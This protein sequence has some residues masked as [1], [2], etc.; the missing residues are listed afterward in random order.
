[1]RTL[2]TAALPYAN[3]PLHLG[4]IRSTYLPG[5][6]CARHNRLVGNDALYIC[7]T[8]EH[9]TP[10]EI[11]AAKEKKTPAEFVKYYYE[12]DKKEFSA[13][14]FSFDIFHH[15]ESK[16]NIAITQDIFNKN[17]KN[18]FI[19]KKQV[20]QFYCEK[21]KTYLPD[22]YVRGICPFCS[23]EDQ[24]GDQCEK[25]GRTFGAQDLKSPHCAICGQAPTLK[26][27]EHYFFKLS[28]FKDEL[29]NYIEGNPRFQKEVK[30]YVLNW[31]NELIDWDI[32]RNLKWGVPIPGEKD[33]VFYVWFDAPIGYISSTVALTKDW[34]KYWK[35]KDARLIHFIGK[36]IIYHHYLF[37]PAMLSGSKDGYAAPYAIPTRGHLTLEGKKFSKSRGWYITLEEYLAVFPPDYLRYYMTAI[38]PYSLVDADFSLQEFK[39]KINNELIANYGNFVFRVE[40]LLKKSCDSKVP[41]VEPDAGMLKKLEGAKI[42]IQKD[43]EAFDYKVA[44]DKTMA[45]SAEF[46]KYIS[47]SEPWKQPPNERD[48]TLATASA[49]VVG[50]SILLSPFI[51]FSAQKALDNFGLSKF[52]WKD[53]GKR[54]KAIKEV[55]PLFRKVEDAELEK[56]IAPAKK[57]SEEMKGA[58]EE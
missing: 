43:L 52:S 41:A 10:I 17:A 19:F 21:D 44:L 39:A 9:G 56:L 14:G 25:C 4:H 58:K 51:P 29:K 42:E 53:I 12:R 22:R 20:K 6:I 23:A 28:A 49:G 27:S 46:N 38:T 48:R 57:R 47:E 33:L 36:D 40:N 11:N 5:D 18:G 32:S 3:G 24:Y 34:Q 30:A 13:L 1:M 55:V 45:I 50:I 15:T 31:I 16:E 8:D 35:G 2:I 37:W 54:P 26:E 7:A